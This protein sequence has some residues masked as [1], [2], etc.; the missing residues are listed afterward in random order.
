MR[1]ILYILCALLLS[2]SLS[3]QT[4]LNHNTNKMQMTVFN[5][6]YLGHGASGAGGVGLTYDGNLDALYTGGLMI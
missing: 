5:N 2:V 4:T 1:N 6:G 3:A